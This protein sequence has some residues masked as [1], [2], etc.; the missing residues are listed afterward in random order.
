MPL[1]G[2]PAAKAGNDYEIDWT[3]YQ[4]AK[5]IDG[6]AERIQIE[7]LT[8]EKAEFVITAGSRQE[9]HQAK[10]SHTDGKWS[11]SILGSAKYQLLQAI[12]RQLS[13]NFNTQFV[14]VSGSDAPELR[15]LADH[16]N[17]AQN[18]NEFESVFVSAQSQRDKFK[19]L[20]GYWNNA[21]TAAIFDLL[22]RI[23]VRTIDW[24]TVKDLAQDLLAALFLTNPGNVYDALYRLAACRTSLH[25]CIDREQLISYLRSKNFKF[26]QLVKPNEAPLLISEVTDRYIEITHRKLIQDSLIPRS[27]T[28]ELLTCIK[29]N[30]TGSVD[31]VIT[32]KAGGGKTA[33]VIECIEKLRQGSHPVTV[34]AFRLDRIDTVSSTKKLGEDLGL[35]ESPAF[36]LGTAAEATSSEA[37]LI[38]DQL[39]AISRTSGRSSEF[40]DIIDDLLREARGWRNRV[41][42]FHVFVVCRK[43]D[44]KNEHHLRRLLIE[45]HTHISVTD[46]SLE[47]VKSILHEGNFKA[48][49]FT[50]KQL[51]LLRLPQN[52]SLFLDIKLDPV[53]ELRFSSTK[54]LFDHYW[55]KK[56]Q[57]VNECVT[58][59]ADHWNDIIQVLCNEMST[60]QRL[61]VLK[62]KLDIFPVDYVHQMA[63]EG[64]LS[65]DDRCYG[66]GHETFF[67]Y[68]FARGFVA[69]EESL[70]AFLINSGQ[71]LFRR[72]Q[73]RQVL[74]YLRDANRERYCTEL[75]ALLEEGDI[76]YHIKALACA[77]GVE[78]PDPE[79]KEWEV[80]APW[81]KS[82]I[83]AIKRGFSNPDKFASLVWNRFFFSQPW[84]Q[85]ADRK[86][87]IACWLASENDNLVNSAVSYA[88]FHQRHSGDRVAELLEPFVDRGGN[89][90]QRFN[91]IMQW[92]DHGNSRRFFN[93]FLRLIDDGTLDSAR[94]PLATNSTFWDLLHRLGS[95]LDWVPEVVA[96][97]LSRRLSIIRE[98]KNS[99]GMPIWNNLLSY[100]DFNSKHIANSANESPEEFVQHVLPVVLKIA[101]EAVSQKNKKPP[102]RDAVW[103][104]LI[105]RRHNSRKEDLRELIAV[106]LHKLAEFNP[107]CVEDIH[108]ELREHDTYIANFFLLQVYTVGAEHFADIAVSE[109][110]DKIWRFDCGY[111]DS[112]YWIAVQLIKE[113]APRCSENNRIKLEMAIL[114]YVPDYERKPEGREFRG[115]A[116]FDLLSGVPN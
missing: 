77:L 62:E 44:W 5:I 109:L 114:D 65:Y 27:S 12:F 58:L 102:R 52:L 78:M 16:A 26:R 85:V 87:L 15:E 76:R 96:H 41:K 47:E 8:V 50:A 53:S 60:T 61:S 107:D 40:F 79:D 66:F 35:E 80:L 49:S 11:L 33:C 67:D 112:P 22:Q 24:R 30:A 46:F 4:L 113:I 91:F 110:C 64:V 18:L 43:F 36:V 3:V 51:E 83:E 25:K 93:L 42:K 54:E 71:H 39:D 56:R 98:T 92:A 81:L 116:S 88:R 57:A 63:S 55:N 82:E 37:V 94:G 17:S 7:A 48:E 31:C 34:L 111:S 75:R 115:N 1:P 100:G 70:T 86:G 72:A 84:F 23:E 97:W 90:P 10:C 73:V 74:V 29:A 95:R 108:N 32:G 13:A 89:W 9:L 104:T 69:Q 101:G 68:C 38:I 21:D 103:S 19:T 105:Y 45:K 28:Q 14:F 99:A 106:A 59:P 20:K 2:G 6:Q